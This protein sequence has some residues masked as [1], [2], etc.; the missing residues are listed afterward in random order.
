M[1]TEAEIDRQFRRFRRISALVGWMPRW[2]A[3]AFAATRTRWMIATGSGFDVVEKNLVENLAPV[4]PPGAD[5]AAVA[6]RAMRLYGHYVMDYFRLPRLGRRRFQAMFRPMIGKDILDRALAAGHGA[7]LATPHLGHWELG[8]VAL[9]YEGL[10]VSVVSAVDTIMPGLTVF[11]DWTRRRHG[12]E[13]INIEPGALAPLDLLRALDANRIVC[14]LGDKNYFESD[15][16]D[17]EFFGRRTAL[18]RGPALLSIAS[19]APLLPSFVTFADGGLYQAE[20][21]APIEI[22][23]E[24]SKSERAAAMMQSLARVFEERIRRHPE[25][26]FVFDPYWG[27]GQPISN[28]VRAKMGVGGEA[29]LK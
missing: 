3:R 1:A 26:W 20:M 9:R 19:G 8:G 15:P 5:A 28:I 21:C 22:P 25:Q 12:I 13:V 24:G 6:R 23:K 11:R 4:L 27:E 18:P 14:V 29:P 2:L 16:A 17:V 10:P 7:L